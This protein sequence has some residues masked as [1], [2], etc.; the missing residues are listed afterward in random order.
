MANIKSAKKRILVIEAK[1]LRNKMSR[2]QLKTAIKAFEKAIKD[3]DKAVAQEKYVA[4]IKK[5]DRA[6]VHGLI[7][8]NCAARKKSQFTKALNALNA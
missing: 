7:H 8:K 2:S 3:G 4:V 1:T 6:A 5:I